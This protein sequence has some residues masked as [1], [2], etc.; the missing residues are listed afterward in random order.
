MPI[1]V[2]FCYKCHELVLDLLLPPNFFPP[3]SLSPLLHM[4]INMY[5]IYYYC[6][7]DNYINHYY[8]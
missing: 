5:I 4:F 3:L 6:C 1:I 7:N 8:Y 2:H